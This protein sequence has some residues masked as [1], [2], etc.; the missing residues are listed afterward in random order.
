MA[1]LSVTALVAGCGGEDPQ[2][3][4]PTTAEA[5]P[6]GSSS[7]TE[8]E[9]WSAPDAPTFEASLE[10]AAQPNYV[11]TL[12]F[13]PDG[14]TFASGDADGTVKLWDAAGSEQESFEGFA[15]SVNDL[16]FSPDG[17]VL[18]TAAADGTA[19]LWDVASGEATVLEGAT[20]EVRAIAFT[21]DG[22]TVATGSWDGSVRL[23]DL[24]GNVVSTLAVEGGVESL[25]FSPDGSVLAV[26]GPGGDLQLWA[27]PEWTRERAVDGT[28]AGIGDLTFSADGQT[29]YGA[30]N[31]STVTVWNAADG[32]VVQTLEGYS[33]YVTSV[34]LSPDG[35][36]L[37]SGSLNG[38]V[39][40]HR[41]DGYEVAGEQQNMGSVNAVTFS[42][43]EP[44]LL[45]S[46]G[47]R[48]TGYTLR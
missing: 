46:D 30:T 9:S 7:P 36:L 43:S 40:L 4:E 10:I 19:R 2:D 29:L 23:Y 48:I 6:A 1:L 39:R 17:A 8:A 18:A 12:A 22:A 16:A 27:G 44:L 26:G 5:S 14:G 25:E 42:P 28:G 20:D 35:T 3:D 47:E 13:S 24:E 37:A 15:G 32:S 21:P 41:T 45:T 31:D 34:A 38:M 33:N 11:Y